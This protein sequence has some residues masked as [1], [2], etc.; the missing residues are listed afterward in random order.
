MS[1]EDP[2]RETIDLRQVG[3]ATAVVVGIIGLAVVG[4]L[5]ID[6][7]LLLFLGIVLAAALQPWH[8]KL[9]R[10]GVP[11]GLAVLLIYLLFL[12]GLVSVAL[13]VG[14]VVIEQVRIF[15]ADLPDTYARL[16]S[17]LLASDTA[18]LR[19]IGHRLPPFEVLTRAL[20]D[21]SPR[22][23]EGILGFTTGL[24]RLFAYF[25]TV[26]AVGFYWTM[27]VPRLERLVLSFLP[28]SRRARTLTIWHEIESKLGAYLRGQGLAMIA[29]GVASAVGYA[30]IG[31]PNVL[32]LGVLAGLLEAVPLFGPV[33]AAAPA[34]LVALPLGLPTVVLVIGL[35]TLLQLVENNI[36]IPRI[37]SHAVG[38]SALVGL[39]AVLAFGTLYGVLG[40]F[41]A[42]PMT[43]VVQVIVDRMLINAEPVSDMRSVEV[44]PFAA[45]RVHVRALGQQARARLR[46][47]GSRMGIDPGTADHVVDAVDQ[48]IEEAV[49]RVERMISVAQDAATPMPPNEREA[50]VEGLH[51][52][53]EDVEQAI[54]RVDTIVGAA[55]E[56]GATS[57]PTVE[58]PVE[59]LSRATQH[60]E[61]AVER[62][63]SVMV[64]T[65]EAPGPIEAE[66]KTTI[67]ENLSEATQQI[68][69]AVRD[70]D[71]LVEAAEEKPR[72]GVAAFVAV[73]LAIAPF[74]ACSRGDEKLDP[75][76]VKAMCRASADAVIAD[77]RAERDFDDAAT[78]SKQGR[79]D[80]SLDFVGERVSSRVAERER[81]RRLSAELLEASRKRTDTAVVVLRATSDISA[82]HA[83]ALHLGDEGSISALDACQADA[84]RS[85]K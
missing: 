48:R 66:A 32:V 13:L 63:E 33:L 68:R 64:V 24:L 56:G 61:K 14:P 65:D 40:V 82:M 39:V 18:P 62:V 67:V 37:M 71:A 69:E 50:I 19:L 28:V 10:W 81:W 41:I 54:E 53:T 4:Y 29:I 72:R 47:R 77:R 26:L 85:S 44:R 51:E 16:R 43:A 7:L 17:T 23:Y 30:A 12:V 57:G 52:A 6:I 79:W 20:M 55:Q 59:E 38:V 84:D 8:V 34:I 2:T 83:Q 25:V 11:K 74:A 22:F 27:E 15:A 31:L 75:A 21:V 58:L 3:A 76:A 70:V 73:L 60:V 5:L 36:L 80:Q 1:N 9:C 49:E 46:A 42:I 78:A 35:A 45:L